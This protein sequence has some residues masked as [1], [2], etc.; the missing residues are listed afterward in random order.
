MCSGRI[1]S[2]T[3]QKASAPKRPNALG[4]AKG[5]PLSVRSTSGSPYSRKR[6]SNAPRAGAPR[7]GGGGPRGT[8]APPR[9]PPRREP[10][11]AGL[12]T[13][14]KLGADVDDALRA[15]EARLNELQSLAHW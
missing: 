10:L 6:R 7:G 12:L 3:H 14:A 5:T 4:W 8:P 9:A 15:I 2:R 1:P 11:L 13:D